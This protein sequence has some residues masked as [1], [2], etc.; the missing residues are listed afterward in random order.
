MRD[1][2]LIVWDFD[3]V[4]NANI[5]DGR[6]FW[7]DR[8]QT[9]LGLDPET[10]AD[11][12]FRSG[13]M[14]PVIAGEIDVLDALSGYLA[15]QA[16]EVTA[17]TLLDYWL[18]QDAM[19]DTMVTSW[20]M[21]HP[22]RRVIGTNNEARRARHIMHQ[23]GYAARVDRMFCSGEMRVAKPDAA[24]F[25]QITN[26]SGV[27]PKRTAFVDDYDANIAQASRMGWQCFHFTPDTRADLPGWLGLPAL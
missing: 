7:S 19:E 11:Y 10:L 21:A 17:Q 5:R 13:R 25:Q 18:D 26:W 15:T 16:T 8:M 2:D 14:K 22:A 27:A 9:D 3:G 6:F 23:M 4:L 1:V 24:F 12:L 20:M